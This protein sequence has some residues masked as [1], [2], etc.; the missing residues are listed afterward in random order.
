MEKRDLASSGLRTSV[1][2][3]GTAALA[4][5]YGPPR[6]ERP[7]PAR[8]VAVATVVRA[9]ERGVRFIDT[10]PAYGDA[11][12]IIADAAPPADCVLATKLAIPQVPWRSLSDAALR[13]HLER[14][15]EASACALRREVIDVLQVHNLEPNEAPRLGEAL[16]ALR[17]EGAV[18][19]TGATVYGE[20]AALAAVE[21]FDLVQVAM[22]VLD[23]RPAERVIPA[24]RERGVAIVT[25]SVLLRG[26][27]SGASASAEGPFAQLAAAADDFRRAS[28][29]SWDELPGAAVAGIVAEPDVTC[30][31]VGPRDAAELDALLDGADAFRGRV[32][33]GSFGTDLSAE[34]LDPSRW[35]ALEAKV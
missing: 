33:A 2:G 28:G 11:E 6:S 30:V 27:L 4:V 35:A 26:V 25:R 21:H 12:S 22:S 7:A 23:R 19:L 20:Q 32:P 34:L 14:S 3:L 13:E 29:A 10:A 31:L 15:V 1:V 16:R 17:T 9:L 5:P 18:K 8:D 24:A